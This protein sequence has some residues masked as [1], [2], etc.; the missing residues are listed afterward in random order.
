LMAAPDVFNTV[1][2]AADSDHLLGA[3]VV[4]VAI[5]ATAEVAR[6]LRFLNI[7]L[8]VAIIVAPLVSEASLLARLNDLAVGVVI[9][10]LSLPRGQI[11]NRYGGWNPWI[12]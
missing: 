3:L 5:T 10:A 9:I 6:A 11:R 1:G 4:V 12:V 8:A 2:F 7:L